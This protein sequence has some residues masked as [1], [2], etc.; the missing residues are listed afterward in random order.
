MVRSTLAQC[1]QRALIFLSLVL[2]Q[3][4]M[5]RVGK[6][7]PPKPVMTLYGMGVYETRW[8]YRVAQACRTLLEDC[9][10]WQGALAVLAR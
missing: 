2:L 8:F 3:A 5:V 4:T 9:E 7:S 10:R 1:D 6:I